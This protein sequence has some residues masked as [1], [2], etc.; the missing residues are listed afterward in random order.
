MSNSKATLGFL[1]GI[2]AGAILG[3]LF[4]PDSGKETRRKISKKT[5]DMGDSLK[6]SFN[7]FVDGLKNSY[8]N[9]KEDVED[10]METGKS[11]MSSYKNEAKN[12]MS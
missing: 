11:K 8:S 7:D 10:M 5:S 1:A 12:S 9:A 4:A 6:N 2:A 3:I